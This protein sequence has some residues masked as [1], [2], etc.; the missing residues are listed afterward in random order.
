MIQYVRLQLND[1]NE[2][3]LPFLVYQMQGIKL[4]KQQAI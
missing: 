4:F 1:M 2:T 3:T